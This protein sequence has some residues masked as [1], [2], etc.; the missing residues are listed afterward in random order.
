MPG[1]LSKFAIL[2]RRLYLW[3]LPLLILAIV[4]SYANWDGSFAVFDV[5]RG[6]L[7]LWF[8]FAWILLYK[9]TAF[10]LVEFVTLGVSSFSHLITTFY[11]L[12]W[13]VLKQQETIGSSSYWTTL[14]YI[15]I[16]V[17]L[18]GRTGAIY[19]F[20]L[21][22][23][24]FGLVLLFWPELTPE[25]KD[26]FMQYMLANL[27]YIS[28]LFASLRI[29]RTYT[30]SELLE[31]MAYQDS[32]TGIANRRQLLEWI[33]QLVKKQPAHMSVIFF[34]I[35][36]F[37]R[38]NDQ[39]GHLIGDQVLVEFTNVI[40][41]HIQPEDYF[42]RWGGEEF[43][44][45]TLQSL[46]ETIQLAERLKEIVSEHCFTKVGNVTSSFGVDTLRPG[47]QPDS[48]FDRADT[49]L[50]LAKQ[51]GRNLVKVISEN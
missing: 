5:I 49:A 15:Y 31:K 24:T 10:R 6:I 22:L 44:V 35:D 19:S 28:F 21:W 9:K 41:E 20:L 2:K 4:S 17:T 8:I 50:Y 7:V 34:D 36:H 13:I 26:N 18:K 38:I 16:F 45:I 23:A 40:K 11:S 3:V 14:I 25:F 1:V 29:M 12:N 39:F 43:V 42:G 27:V 32:L 47:E 48:L 46:P 51:E 33:E 37:K 30:E